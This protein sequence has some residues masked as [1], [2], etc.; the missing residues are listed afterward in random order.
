M[1][2]TTIIFIGIA[3][4]L[5]FI[6]LINIKS[7]IIYEYER[8]LFYNKG[9]FQK[10]LGPGQH[11]YFGS[12][13]KINKVDIRAHSVTIPNQ[14]ILSSDN[15]GIK[16]SLAAIFKIENP[17]RAMVEVV[18]YAQAVYLELQ[19]NLRDIVGAIPVDDFLSKRQEIG[20][21]LLAQTQQ[22]VSR[23]GILLET[24]AI[25]DIMFPGDLK[26]VFAQVVNAKKEGLAALERARGESAA[27]RNLANTANLL[28]KNP[29]LFQLRLLQAVENHSGNTI[30]LGDVS[31]K[32]LQTKLLSKENSSAKKIELRPTPASADSGSAA[33]NS[34]GLPE[35]VHN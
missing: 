9:K 8:G 29:W 28:E 16:V 22:K 4:A 23:Y 31:E 18:D 30:I 32:S 11:W 3:V 6:F 10:E 21:E 1:D 5:I 20:K 27:L 34:V 26:N 12:T 25:K 24:V 35:M 33:Q 15:I 2:P 19:V 17:Y 13:K 7:V 14:E